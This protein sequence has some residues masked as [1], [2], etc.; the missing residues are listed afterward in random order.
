MLD[1]VERSQSIYGLLIF[2]LVFLLSYI[3]HNELLLRVLLITPGPVAV[4]WSHQPV[5]TIQLI[6]NHFSHQSLIT[7]EQIIEISS[8]CRL[9]QP[10]DWQER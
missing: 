3:C 8:N 6:K 5:L 1:G 4:G 2:S 7:H 10:M 9:K